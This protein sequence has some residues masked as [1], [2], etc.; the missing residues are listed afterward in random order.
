MLLLFDSNPNPN[1]K[2]ILK[3]KMDSL[4]G[5]ELLRCS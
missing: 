3:T 5:R 2:L 4:K 1:A